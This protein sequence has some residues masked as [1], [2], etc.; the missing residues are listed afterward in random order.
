MT[1][2]TAADPETKSADL[3]AE[4]LGKLRAFFPDAFTEG[5]V[6]FVYAVLDGQQRLT[7]LFI[8]LRG[9]YVRLSRAHEI[10]CR[11]HRIVLADG[12]LRSQAVDCLLQGFSGFHGVELVF[13]GQSSARARC[14]WNARCQWFRKE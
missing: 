2:L 3:L 6:D 8:G 11:Q 12:I 4:N 7:A 13:G 5:G 14:S 9:S 10:E 1:P